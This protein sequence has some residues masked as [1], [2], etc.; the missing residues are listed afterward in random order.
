MP[1]GFGDSNLAID[2][3]L[4]IVAYILVISLTSRRACER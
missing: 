3:S 1:A 4:V 2:D